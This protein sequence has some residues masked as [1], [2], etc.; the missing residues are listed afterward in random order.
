MVSIVYI[1]RDLAWM[2]QSINRIFY[3]IKDCSEFILEFV[4]SIYD[5]CEFIKFDPKDKKI[6][7]S[8]KHSL[9]YYYY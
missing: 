2:R 1:E 3:E 9:K 4:I 6:T 7:P 8:N 5:Q